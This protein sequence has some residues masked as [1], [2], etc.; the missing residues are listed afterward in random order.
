MYASTLP[1]RS[2]ESETFRRNLGAVYACRIV[3]LRASAQLRLGR[4]TDAHDAVQ[5]AFLHVLENP[6][7]DT[8]IA[9]LSNALDI[10]LRRTTGRFAETGR[11]DVALARA[12]RERIAA[13]RRPLPD[14]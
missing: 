4:P 13:A 12:S 14:P 11:S 2:P 3:A 8:S 5:E 9:S 1:D 7:A 6:P 10:A